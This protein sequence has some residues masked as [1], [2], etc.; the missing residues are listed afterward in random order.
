MNNRILI[1]T[2]YWPPS[3]GSG[4]QRWLKFAKYLPEFG[5]LP[6]VLTVKNPTYPFMD[7]SLSEDVPEEATVE[8]SFSLEPFALFGFLTGKSAKEVGSPVTGLQGEGQS[9]L[10][11]ISQWVRANLFIP[12]ARRGWVPFSRRKALRMINQFN[13]GTVVTTGPP[14]SVHFIGHYVQKKTGIRW[15]ADFRDPWV[16]VHYNL[17]LPRMRWAT[18]LDRR[19]ERRILQAADEAIVVSN[20]MADQF[21]KL[22]DRPY[23]VI[24][25]GYDPQD[26]PGEPVVLE[27]AFTVRYVGKLGE[28]V[29]PYG[30]IKALSQVESDIPFQIEFIGNVHEKLPELVKS[31]GLENRVIFKPY[32]PMKQA[33]HELCKAHILLLILP[34]TPGN[35]LILSGKLFN[36]IGAG[37]PIVMIGP[38]EGDAARI[39]KE[40]DFGECFNHDDSD[41][42]KQWFEQKLSD[43]ASRGDKATP[44]THAHSSPEQFSRRE[45][46]GKLTKLIQPK[47]Q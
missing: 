11:R 15:I 31:H 22:V 9:L 26:F 38:T 10:T 42:L 39:I 35:E 34:D 6:F 43:F 21:R 40:Y 7:E 25:N 27:E 23:H 28:T 5:L 3:G 45:L 13:I 44:G 30:L 14:H 41:S 2:Y 12:D 32:M 4:V 17:Y 24:T 1:I 36:Y 19:Y 18:R 29:I 47:G 37:R 16:D 33:N 20:T 8:T 46:T